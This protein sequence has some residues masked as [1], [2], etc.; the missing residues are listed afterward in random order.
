MIAVVKAPD[1]EAVTAALEARGEEVMRIGR[2]VARADGAPGV[3]Y[4]GT[5]KL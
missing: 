5:L 2:L 4:K 3:S 1:A